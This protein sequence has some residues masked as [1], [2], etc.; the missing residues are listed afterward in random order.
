[1]SNDILVVVSSASGLTQ[2]ITSGPYHF[3]A[4]EPSE[5]GGGGVGPSPYEL[6]LASLGA[7]TSMTLRLYA[8]RKSWDLQQ[9][10]VRLRHSRVHA[11]DCIDC[12][13]KR[14]FLDR[15]ER[16][17]QVTGSLSDEQKARLQVIAES[18]PVHRT[19]TSSSDIR[20]S[21]Y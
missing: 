18:C 7:C 16:E 10:T 12:E 20:T 11:A 9:I 17:I 5:L 3:T 6:L 21:L 19:L 1:M 13:K 8:S 2:E 4:D 14:P 15:I